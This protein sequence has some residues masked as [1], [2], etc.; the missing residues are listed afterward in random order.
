MVVYKSDISCLT[1]GLAS[2]LDLVSSLLVAYGGNVILI[3]IGGF[4]LRITVL[5]YPPPQ[6]HKQMKQ[7]GSI[8]ANICHPRAGELRQVDC[9]F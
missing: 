8:V 6:K 1:K 5:K 7:N 2:L 4:G 3:I 9:V